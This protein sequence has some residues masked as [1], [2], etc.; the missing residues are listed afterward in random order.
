MYRKE[1][2]DYQ[3]IILG[4]IGLTGIVVFA[5]LAP[6][7]VQL[8]QYLPKHKHKKIHYVNQVTK[9]LIER[10]LVKLSTNNRGQKVLRL[11]EKGR[12]KLQEYK[13][14]EL[15]II[16]PKKWDSKYRVIIF[17]IKEWK[18]PI[19]DRL[20]KWLEHLGLVRLQNSVW[21]Y[22]Y[23]C[24]EII[25]LLKANYHIGKEVLYM[26]VNYLENDL[27]LKKIFELN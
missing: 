6:N 21:V 14:S 13:L 1:K 3:E 7:C 15:Q 9:K 12:I 26:E 19:R 27:W 11:T 20:R 2:I 22:P 25:A 23:D 17:D 5:L 24:Q 4:V 16:K 18:R 10:R 8:L